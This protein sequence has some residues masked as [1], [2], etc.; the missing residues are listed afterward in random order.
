MEPG[1][2]HPFDDMEQRSR[3]GAGQTPL[4]AAAYWSGP[5]EG[6]V[7]AE[8]FMTVADLLLKSGAGLTARGA[9]ALG[10]AEWLRAKH[11][12]GTLINR[13]EESGGLLRIA[14]S[15]NRPE[16]LALLLELGFDPNERTR[17]RDVGGDEVVFTAGMPLWQCAASGR[18]GM[19]DMLLIHRADPNADAYAS[20]TPLNQAYGRRDRAMIELLERYGGRL[21]TGDGSRSSN[22]R[23]ESGIMARNSGPTASGIAAPT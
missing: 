9:V 16:I 22:N 13:I 19:A 14:V 23:F 2:V 5:V 12:E 1:L 17:V 6:G 21:E 20:G 15:H 10:N 3:G 11:A 4:D 18:Y 8:R 7:D